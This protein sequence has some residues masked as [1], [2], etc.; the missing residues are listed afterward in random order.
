MVILDFTAPE[1]GSAGFA[2]DTHTRDLRALAGAVV[3]DA[4][5]AFPHRLH[6]RFG[7]AST[8]EI[9]DLL[10]TIRYRQTPG[11]RILDIVPLLIDDSAEKPRLIRSATVGDRRRHH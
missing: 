9:G 2:S 6:L 1:L 5:H 11:V 3:D 7:D 8:A 10:G 4:P